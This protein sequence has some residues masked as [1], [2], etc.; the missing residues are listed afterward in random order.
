M[1]RSEPLEGNEAQESSGWNSAVTSGNTTDSS[2]EESLE[3]EPRSGAGSRMDAR[4]DGRVK[5]LDGALPAIRHRGDA[6]PGEEKRRE[7][8]GRGDTTRRTARGKL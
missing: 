6:V 2:D 1:D 5:R 8:R 4:A 3:V 7:G